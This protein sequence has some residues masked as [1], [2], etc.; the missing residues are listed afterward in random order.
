MK[1]SRF[2]MF[3]FVPVV[4]LDYSPAWKALFSLFLYESEKMFSECSVCVDRCGCGS[5]CMWAPPSSAEVSI[6]NIK[7]VN[8]G[9]DLFSMVIS[10]TRLSL[11]NLLVH[12][13]LR[14]LPHATVALVRFFSDYP[15][16]ED[17]VV[18]CNLLANKLKNM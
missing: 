13:V 10:R 4:M 2:C 11:C 7:T 3:T 6:Q 16:D 17:T 18:L 15:R 9:I 5:T 12:G 14:I 8:L 1:R